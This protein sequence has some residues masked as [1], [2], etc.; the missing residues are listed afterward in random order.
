MT[1]KMKANKQIDE[2]ILKKGKGAI[3]DFDNSKE[4]YV[5]A[6]RPE[7]KLISIRLPIDMIRSLR[8]MAVLKGDIGYQQMI[9][10]YIAEGIWQDNQ[11]GQAVSSRPFFVSDSPGTSSNMSVIFTQ[12]P[13]SISGEYAK[14]A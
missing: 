3:E 5:E 13:G 12:K 4:V 2:E 6:T 10:T 11:R 14:I 1:R 9:K 7:S 8:Q